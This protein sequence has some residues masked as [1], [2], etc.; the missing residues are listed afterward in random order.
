VPVLFLL[1]L[2]PL[3]GRA[4]GL[5]L[6]AAPQAVTWDGFTPTGW[7]TTLP[8]TST[9]I[10][11]APGGLETT[12][13]AYAVSTDT[14]NTWSAWSTAGLTVGGAIS[15]TQTITVTGLTLPDSAT[16]NQIRFRI[17]ETGRRSPTGGSA[18]ETSPAYTIMVDATPPGPPQNLQASPTTWTN[19]ANFSVSW[20]NPTDLTPITGSW[21]KLDA[22][23]T[24]PNDG[25]FVAIPPAVGG[26]I[27]G[28]APTG[29]AAHPIYVWLQDQFGRADHTRAAG[30]T[31]YLDQTPPGAPSGLQAIPGR[32][33][34]NV[35]RF[36]E[37]WSNP[38][39]L[40][41]IVGAYYQINRPGT[42][43][44]DGVFVT[45]VNEINDIQV[46]AD[47]Q[48][49][50]YLWLVDA[51]GNVNH[52]NRNVDPKAFWYDSTPPVTTVTLNPALPAGGWYRTPVT[53]TLTAADAAGGSGVAAIWNQLDST[54]WSTLP[55]LRVIDE[56]VHQLAY[57]ATDVAGNR[58]TT[59]NLPVALDFTPPTVTLT[60]ARP[61]QASGWY[62]APVTLSLA[63]NDTLSGAG[64][65]YYR[66]DGGAWLMGVNGV[67]VFDFQLATDG[68]HQVDYYAEDL[69]GNRCAA[70]TIEV[71][72][73]ITPPVSTI[74]GPVSGS[75]IR[76]APAIGGSANDGGTSSLE[77]GS[78][79]VAVAVSMRANATGFFWNGS[80]WGGS[81]QWLAAAGTMTWAYTAAQ[82][83]WA[84]GASYTVRS[85]GTDMAGNVETPGPGTTFTFDVTPPAVSLISPN[86][87]EV[88][89]GGQV[90]PITWNAADTVGLAASPITL[91]VSYD[92][93][94]HWQIVATELPNSSSYAW[95]APNVDTS[96]ALVEVE[97][98]DRAGNRRADRS[99]ATFTLDS[100]APGAPQ[101]LQASPTTW[102]NQ[103][104]FSVSWTNPP[105]TV[106][107]IGAWY[108]LDFPPVASDDGI[109]VV[110]PPAG[111]G[112]I[113]GITP[114]GDAIHPIYV[115]LQDQL[116]RADHTH[117]ASAMLY[118]DQ[119]SP[120]PP[121]GLQAIPGRTWTNV[122]RFSEQWVNPPDLS[123]IVGAYYRINRPGMFPTDGIFVSLPPSSGTGT[124]NDL[125]MPTDGQHDLYIWLVDAAGNVNHSNRN[126]DPRA[127]WYDSTPPVTTV[128]LTPRPPTGG[129]YRTPFTV[130]LTASDGPSGSGV[131]GVFHQLND[132]PWSTL[133]SLQIND[134]G[135][136]RLA[137]YAVDVAG[138]VETTRT[139]PLMLDF[140]PPLVTL[141]PDRPPLASG[142]YTA[143]VTLSLM[144][145]DTLSGV[146]TGYYRVNGGMSSL[147]GGS[148]QALA[149]GASFQLAA[150]GVHQVDYYAEDDAGNTST[151]QSASFQI[152]T[153][154]PATAYLIEGNQGQ[155]GWYTSALTVR[156]IPTDGPGSP[157]EGGTAS[158]EGGSGV[159]ATYYQINNGPWQT[160]TQF[161]LTA[162]GTYVLSFYSVDVAGNIET[163][164]PV[165]VRLDR[166]APGAPTAVETSPG[167]W[168]QVNRFSV[169]WA[170]PTDLS[171]IAGVYYRLNREPTAPDDG[172]F[173]PLTNR[174]D[175]LTVPAEGVHR[176]YLWLRDGAGN[177]DHRNYAVAPVL[178]Y[179]AT[180]PTTVLRVQ[181]VAG[182]GGWYRSPLALTLDA[183]DSH[184]GVAGTRYRLN[185]GEWITATALNLATADKHVLEFASVDVA[186]NAEAVQRVTL[187]IDPDPPTAPLNLQAGPTGWQ[188]YNSFWLS[189]RDPLDQS[190]IAGAYVRFDSPPTGPTA[191]VFYTASQLLEGLS[192]PAVDPRQGAEGQHDL[193]VWLRDR[194]GNSDHNAAVALPAALWYDGTPPATVITLT[195]S[196]GQNNWYIGPVSFEMAATDATSGVVAT[197]WQLDVGDWVTGTAF[198][199]AQDGQHTVRI[200][201]SDVAGNEEPAHVYAVAIDRRPPEV[202]MGALSHYQSSTRFQVT[203]AG[204]DDPS[205]SGLADFDVQVRDGLGGLWANWLTRTTLTGA[206]FNGERGHTYFF[207]VKARD[208]AGNEASFTD[209]SSYTVIENVR[210]GSFDTG[211]FSEWT[212]S[213]LLRKAVVPVEGPT[214]STVLAARLGSPEYGPSVQEP[215][216]VPVGSA[217][218]SQT[219]TVPGVSE[220]ARPT[221][222]F[223]YRVFSYDVLY[224]Q[225]LQTY[226]DALEVSIFDPVRQSSALLLRDGNNTNVY[227]SLYD[228]GWRFATLNLRPYAGQTVQLIFSNYNRVDNLFN[229]WSFVDNIQVQDWPYNE[230]RY[231]PLIPGGRPPVAQAAAEA[232]DGKR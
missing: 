205:G 68:V 64:S 168:S 76:S 207:R 188:R 143:A 170:N 149:I 101:N 165:Q 54:G 190:G 29:D 97:A 108:K 81:E 23:P 65:G 78:G 214:G 86:G 159:G 91:T 95:T 80:T 129:W 200:T 8:A 4:V 175:N 227:G 40:S 90:Y 79:L 2:A 154:P 116:G 172:I 46:P 82:P 221:L 161:Q 26:S 62:T 48:H 122:N 17:Q 15:T 176:L 173:S 197:R 185:A 128:T 212:A 166:V 18:L 67:T 73:D 199:L 63:I 209:G 203:W 56:G 6:A 163:S 70:R 85:R 133:T 11:H 194:A 231:L 39:D 204:N 151:V 124:I 115:W 100:S 210:N 201:S 21:Y 32:T 216:Q 148:W 202:R 105:G 142:W 146:N 25:R 111:E 34:T 144:V 195:G 123:G 134:E 94:A 117:T 112:T 88:W 27:A 41:G 75:V 225:R 157:T 3:A 137:W 152:D 189:W 220:V 177:A 110:I 13:A 213:G 45:A 132:G 219:I 224:S 103:A 156:L 178:R 229:T 131:T 171:G 167:G 226:V 51:A 191:G 169:Q 53:I 164:Y 37:R 42:H 125:E 113:T 30:A 208:L 186:G 121:A 92:A 135:L 174:L 36:T 10:A 12:T 187:R 71:R 223:W 52:N 228:S 43:P 180:P 19:Q 196:L 5:G 33:W 20:T 98:L 130:T 118:L 126:V 104:N 150:D 93:G 107:I 61:P 66:V 215:G 153:V 89:I 1:A 136:H 77:G 198:T 179:D 47:G 16:A 31:L 84:D 119:T 9:V 120:A 7:V 58:E 57:Y 206:T 141:A 160:G 193:Y 162:N 24:A 232:P 182:D 109:F 139:A 55:T 181:G 99:D 69:A 140:T 50:L 83:A 22:P 147:E 183:V 230:R 217:T 184:S 155:N 72:L 44:T 211:N 59:R 14:G 222:A 114:T 35:N 138:N 60:P 74:T 106:P 49:D 127:F 192:L 87:G 96:Q 102:T 218:I 145:S 158:L 38:P 28:I